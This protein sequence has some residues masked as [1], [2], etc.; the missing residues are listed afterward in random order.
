M[1]LLPIVERELRVT[2]RLT[3]TYRNRMFTPIA[4]AALSFLRVWLTPRPGSPSMIGK[5][6]FHSLSTLTLAFC[7]LE[8]VR[9]AADC[10]SVEKREGTLGLLFLT[11]LKGYDVILGKLSAAALTSLCALFA[12]LPILGWSIIFFGGVTLGE[13]WRVGIASASVLCFS[14]TVG[15]WVSS[16]SYSASRAM[17]A[18][19][20]LVLFMLL[21][22]IPNQSFFFTPLSPARAFFCAA[23]TVYRIHPLQYW[24]SLA[25]TVVLIWSFLSSASATVNRFREEALT[26]KST[27]EESFTK[28]SQFGKPSRR[29]QLRAKLLAINPMLW[30]ASRG[31]NSSPYAWL[32]AF[33]TGLGVAAFV[34]L[35]S[36]QHYWM[37]KYV[38]SSKF[39][40]TSIVANGAEWAFVIFIAVMNPLFNVLLASQ[41]CRCLA[42]A[43]RNTTLEVLLCSPLRV[44]D[45]LQGQV[46]ALKR[47]FLR[48]LMLLL[49]F[50]IIGVFW[51]LYEDAGYSL[52]HGTF[53]KI[54]IS[55]AALVIF[56]LLEVQAVAWVGM[57]FGLC[58]KTESR[59][60]FKTI[61]YVMLLPY[62]LLVLYCFG[63]IL[64]FAW[65]ILSLMWARLNLQEH[66]RAL[67]GH[68]A[69]SSRESLAW[70]PFDVPAVGAQQPITQTPS[71]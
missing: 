24:A 19:F 25:M 59:A 14:L 15:I 35:T 67:A 34:H 61:F 30:L 69:T 43:R 56:F 17:T 42:E 28:Q 22:P 23:D 46:L 51:L 47:I 44:E 5:N 49:G 27:E 4:V 50:E 57:W 45:I 1:T 3:G 16:R 64:F 6:L 54:I 39:K 63:A 12:I 48:P 11:D 65:P 40:T 52:Q 29:A 20:L 36:P 58:S 66:F 70:V 68:R 7:V 26:V 33:I 55:E 13:L 37:M 31:D 21:A 32:L 38:S 2:S 18:T 53:G 8:G 71:A 41:A 9:K 10:V 62:T 60:M